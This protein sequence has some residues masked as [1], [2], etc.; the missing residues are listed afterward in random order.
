MTLVNA[1]AITLGQTN[2]RNRF[3]AKRVSDPA[4]APR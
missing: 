1:S 4:T 3:G 2:G